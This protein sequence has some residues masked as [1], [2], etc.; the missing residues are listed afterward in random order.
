MNGTATPVMAT[1]ADA[2]PTDSR[3]FRSVSRPIWKSSRMTPSSARRWMI[4]FPESTIPSTLAP[5]ITPATSSPSTAGWPTRSASSPITFATTRIAT[6]MNRNCGTVMAPSTAPAIAARFIVTPPSEVWPHET[7]RPGTVG[8]GPAADELRQPSAGLRNLARRQ[9][10]S[11]DAYAHPLSRR[12]DD[13]HTTQVRQ[14]RARGLVIRMADVLAERLALIT[15]VANAGHDAPL[16]SLPGPT[17]GAADCYCCAGRTVRASR[18]L[19]AKSASASWF[20]EIAPDAFHAATTE[21][22][23]VRIWP[24][25]SRTSPAWTGIT[26]SPAILMRNG[27]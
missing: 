23:I 24:A 1:T 11:A 16:L 8:A 17:A 12:R 2:G 26:A 4:A 14:P 9:A 19:C 21:S 15:Y 7:E 3:R 6:R 18:K 20:S 27:C 13:T 25:T 22:L 10:A 5:R